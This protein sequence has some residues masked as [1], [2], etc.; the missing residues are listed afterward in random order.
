MNNKLLKYGFGVAA[1]LN[2]PL[3]QDTLYPLLSKYPFWS[4]VW[5]AAVGLY[6]LYLYVEQ[7]KVNEVVMFIKENPEKFTKEIVSSTYF[8]TNFLKFLGDYLK[9]Y[10]K[11]KREFLKKILLNNLKFENKRKYEIDRLN[12]TLSQISISALKNLFWI[13]KEIIPVIEK[14]INLDLLDY[15]NEKDPREI[16]RLKD[17]TKTRK[18]VSEFV[19]QWIHDSYNPNSDKVKQKYKFDKNWSKNE[20]MKFNKERWLEEHEIN[21]EKS[22]HWAEYVNLGIMLAITEGGGTFSGSAGTVYKLTDYGEEFI[23]YCFDNL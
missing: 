16:N 17:I 11:E 18:N 21:K 2:L 23:E 9:Q 5:I 6:N 13:K 12:I 3:L 1:T 20:Q 14:S 10:N 7:D 8:R 4:S 19:S 22:S 15:K